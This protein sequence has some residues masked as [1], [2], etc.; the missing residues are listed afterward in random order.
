MKETLIGSTLVA[1]VLLA[2]LFCFLIGWSK[3]RGD[4]TEES[5][6]LIGAITVAGVVW[7]TLVLALCLALWFVV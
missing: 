6:Y 2:I 1:I 7:E 3:R 4:L 5:F